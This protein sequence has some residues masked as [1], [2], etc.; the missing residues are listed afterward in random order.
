[1]RLNI[2]PF[3]FRDNK[4]RINS[5]INDIPVN[6]KVA[7]AICV[8]TVESSS[9]FLVDYA[10]QYFI[11]YISNNTSAPI[12]HYVSE[13]HWINDN[14]QLQ[15]HL[16]T[17]IQT[18]NACSFI[19]ELSNGQK[20]ES[21]FC[22]I[23]PLINNESK[24]T[25]ISL[26]ISDYSKQKKFEEEIEKY[27]YYDSLT[28][29]PNKGF[30]QKYLDSIFH[31]KQNICEV[32]II[33]IN[34]ARLRRINESYGYL[35]G[36]EV[37][38]T[39]AQKIKVI[40]PKGAH[41]SRFE[42][43]KFV[44]V[45]TSSNFSGIQSE[46]EA[47]SNSLHY[48][49]LKVL[50]PDRHQ[51]TVKI[52]IGIATGSVS[53]HSADQLVQDAH[54]AMQRVDPQSNTRTLIYK[55]DFRTRSESL[56]KLET[57]IHSALINKQLELYYQPLICLN[58]GKL[59]GFESLC[60]WNHP[61]RGMIPPN[62]FIPLAEETGLIIPIGTWCLEQSCTKLKEWMEDNPLASSLMINV[63]ISNTQLA[64]DDIVSVIR[65]IL[66]KTKLPGQFLK[67]EITETTIMENSDLARDILL[68]LKT[69][70]IS[71]AI[72]DFGT[73]YSSLSYLNRF[74]ADTLKVDRSFVSQMDR[75]EE[76]LKIV[77]I[78]TS[79]ASI[80]GM[81]VVAEGIETEKQLKTLR[82]MGCHTGQGY[83][84]SKPLK[85]KDVP[86]YIKDHQT[87][88]MQNK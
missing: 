28:E 9:E 86:K 20:V 80:L 38:K 50:L 24:I 59:T 5:N 29:L 81:N 34:I 56:L 44:C 48:N 53:L 10:N 11:D 39:I 32:A 46:A 8:L 65:D 40:L 23:L 1:M 69:L 71:L 17:C 21:L 14:Q 61:E 76:S 2:A 33:F 74:P 4:P 77:H 73:G 55:K 37:I 49:L 16:E 27:N 60:R 42:D 88:M 25:K 12:G 63:N 15:K 35:F 43:D 57:E 68:D 58:T 41:L 19:W 75:N 54:L 84:F 6:S 64:Q 66:Y 82:Q 83:Y 7:E 13:L 70:N 72:D 31:S 67:L 26:L 47:F 22:H 18:G 45:L 30:F 36:D 78:I 51:I 62:E 52:N 87:K 85:E 79:L 3:L